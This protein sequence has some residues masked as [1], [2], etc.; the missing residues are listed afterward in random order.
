MRYRE[1]MADERDAYDSLLSRGAMVEE[2]GRPFIGVLEEWVRTT[3]VGFPSE[4][5]G[6]CQCNLARAA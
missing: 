3:V 1:V 6:S 5:L 2:A 4:P